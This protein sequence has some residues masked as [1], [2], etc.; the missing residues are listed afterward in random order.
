M[1]EFD[2][3]KLAIFNEFLKKSRSE[4]ESIDETLGSSAEKLNENIQSEKER[5]NL[6]KKLGVEY[7]THAQIAKD[8]LS[9]MNL[10]DRLSEKI[11]I[12]EE[13]RNVL[14]KQSINS[15][16][17]INELTNNNNEL[18]K[19][20]IDE[21]IKR[22]SSYEDFAKAQKE[23]LSV[24]RQQKLLKKSLLTDEQTMLAVI[25]GQVTLSRDGINALE[26]KIA[27][28]KQDLKNNK[29]VKQ[30]LIEIVK[31]KHKEI[32]ASEDIIKG[33]NN[34]IK[35]NRDI[36]NAEINHIENAKREI[37]MLNAETELLKKQKIITESIKTVVKAIAAELKIPTSFAELLKATYDRFK[38]IDKIATDIRQ[39]FGLFPA[40]AKELNSQIM[41][42]VTELA[43]F[44]ASAA[45]VGATL[46]SLGGEFN[47]LTTKN[48][49]LVNDVT[50]LNKQF[51]IS[52][53]V[54]SKF[55]KVMGGVSSKS[56]ESTKYMLNFAG[57][58]AQAYGVGLN[59][60]M[61]DV[62]NASDDTRMYAGKNADEMV[63]AAAQARQ[64]GTSLDNM[65]KTSKGLLDFES[66]IQN[67]L[68]ASALIGKNINFNEARRLAFQGKT[69]EANKIILEQAKKIKFNQLNPIAQEAYAK[70]AGK[71]V[72]ELQDMLEAETRI[73]DA[74]HSQDPAVRKIAQ[75]KLKEQNI[76]KTNKK[77]AQDIFERDL[78]SKANQEKIAQISNKINAQLQKLMLPTL[79][80]I[81]KILEFTVDAFDKLAVYDL[82]APLIKA[83][84]A[85]TFFGEQIR[86]V[87][88]IVKNSLLFPFRAIGGFIEMLGKSTWI[89]QMISPITELIKNTKLFIGN[90]QYARSLGARFADSFVSAGNT[91]GGIFAKIGKYIGKVAESI[92]FVITKFTAFKS[93]IS[94]MF[95]PI[96]NAVMPIMESFGKFLKIG[97]KIGGTFG[98]LFNIFK[99]ARPAIK[100]FALATDAIG[101]GE[102]IQAIMLLID[103]VPKFF[104][105]WTDG[106]LN[107]KQKIFKSFVAIPQAI[108]SAMIEPFVQIGAWLGGVFVKLIGK[109]FGKDVADS[110]IKGIS[111]IKETL[112]VNLVNPFE[113]AYHWIMDKLGGK[114]PSE[115]GLAIVKGIE[116][117]TETLF[118]LITSPFKTGFNIIKSTAIVVA[119]VIGNVFGKAFDTV[120]KA[121]EM[122]WE[123]IKGIGGSI[124]N[125][126]G[127]GITF[128]SK[129]VGGGETTPAVGASTSTAPTATSQP[130]I[131]T[132]LIVNAIVSSNSKVASKIDDLMQMM[133][134]GKIAVY[135]DGQKANQ[136]LAASSQKFG[137]FGQA[138]TT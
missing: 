40:Q 63:R 80:A 126:V 84:I 50:L 118:E 8:S 55:L 82:I 65:A 51:G 53:E 77:L 127:K 78:K 2:P 120:T 35:L 42:S 58:A 93:V 102:I 83:K 23:L 61:N 66:S 69:V 75:E 22:T 136:L 7:R 94:R 20:A 105:I 87:G 98:K 4:I 36:I 48:K 38:E 27:K 18:E 123:K 135:I 13:S 71:S 100:A 103:L 3:K 130:T 124:T 59:D 47:Y 96:T 89:Q 6:A 115:I 79:E 30:S 41:H 99:A 122:V 44:G 73:K 28:N 92:N 37:E 97:E 133:A 114:S 12:A 111:S 134:S 88:G 15:V 25:N 101:I 17:Q 90:F 52:A 11:K 119:D 16:A 125:I 86:A 9:K 29:E 85:M 116:S 76:L 57:A 81:N 138:T 45:D 121:L 10:S 31:N 128:V 112:Y 46:K 113:K 49:D 68:K 24:A 106:T 67:E 70:A 33:L 117:V 14:Q 60:V 107:I 56:A 95:G 72:K 104:N 39:Q 32:A 34:Q 110:I 54:S 21:F 74:L 109:I 137:S 62:A 26:E 5:V 132:D 64:M 108:Y 43:A 131:N 91:V 129:I 19:T 1:T